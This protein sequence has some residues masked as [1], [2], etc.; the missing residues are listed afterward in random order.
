MALYDQMR[1]DVP[2]VLTW[3]RETL[4]GQMHVLTLLL[5]GENKVKNLEVLTVNDQTVAGGRG[6]LFLQTAHQ[7]VEHLWSSRGQKKKKKKRGA[8]SRLC[9]AVTFKTKS[10][11]FITGNCSDQ[12]RKSH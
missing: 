7:T 8:T 12:V 6:G 10:Q 11:S 3:L 1:A 5:P 4:Q 2:R 9:S